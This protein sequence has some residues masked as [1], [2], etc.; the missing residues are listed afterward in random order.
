MKLWRTSPF[1][2]SWDSWGF[3]LESEI[4]QTLPSQITCL[5]E[6]ILILVLSQEAKR[7]LSQ[8]EIRSIPLCTYSLSSSC[9]LK[10]TKVRGPGQDQVQISWRATP[11]VCPQDC[12][13][14]FFFHKILERLPCTSY[15]L[16]NWKAS[17]TQG[18]P[19]EALFFLLNTETH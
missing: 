10:S 17:L 16:N 7:H 13:L 3:R 8:P 11:V 9:C 14:P 2:S 5:S 19:R 4:P 18:E 12:S 1:F 15:K 6:C